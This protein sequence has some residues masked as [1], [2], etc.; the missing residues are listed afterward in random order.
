MD[1]TLSLFDRGGWLVR[2][3]SEEE[4]RSEGWELLAESHHAQIAMC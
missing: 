4:R 1:G 2:Q 3:G